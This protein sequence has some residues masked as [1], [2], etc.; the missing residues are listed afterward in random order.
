MASD[1]ALNLK[2]DTDYVLTTS[3]WNAD[4]DNAA[5]QDIAKLFKDDMGVVLLG[6]TL[7]SVWDGVLLAVAANQAGSTD[8]DAMRA[9][10]AEGL[11]LDPAVDPF[12]LE[13]FIYHETDRTNSVRLSFFS[14]QAASL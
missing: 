8:G 13:G 12:G 9:A 4:M 10:M 1:F 11:D 5:A 2:N 3:R 6:D 14:T 7:T